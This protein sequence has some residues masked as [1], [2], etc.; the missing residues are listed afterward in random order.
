MTLTER[1]LVEQVVGEP[2][3][4]GLTSAEIDAVLEIGYLTIACDRELSHEELERLGQL[5]LSLSSPTIEGES[6]L[7]ASILTEAVE[8]FASYFERD[9]IDGRL[10][11]C[12][13]VLSRRLARDI[14]Y[15][16]ACA[17]A[18]ADSKIDDREFE[19]DLSLIAAL[20]LT[21]DEADALADEVRRIV[22]T[23]R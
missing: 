16:A 10:E 1:L 21:Q 2:N 8:R 22:S 18:L 3:S 17:L 19:L 4:A 9:G 5:S 7:G 14:A 20:G 12:A 15:K 6:A 11:I 13:A 23:P